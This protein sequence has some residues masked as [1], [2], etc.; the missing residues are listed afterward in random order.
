M[1]KQDDLV[2]ENLIRSRNWF[3][4]FLKNSNHWKSYSDHNQLRITRIIECLR[5][6]I[7]DKEADNFY[8]EITQLVG[9]NP[10][11]NRT[12]LEFWQNA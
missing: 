1:L 12:T 7:N 5:L 3:I 11:I 9:E 2:Q 10:K 8:E 4:K 6:I